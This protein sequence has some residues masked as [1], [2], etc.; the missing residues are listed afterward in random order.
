MDFNL[1]LYVYKLL[2]PKPNENV[3][4]MCAS[5]GNKTTH[6]AQLMNDTGRLIA[7]DKSKSRTLV[8]KENIQRFKFEC[9]EC[10]NFDATKAISGTSVNS[11]TPPFKEETFDKILLDA[12]CS[13][14]G[15]RPILKSMITKKSV[16]SFP[17]L[18]KRLLEVGMKLLKIDGILVYS[19]CSVL[20]VEN[21]LNVAWI[22][23][24]Y[25]NKIELIDATP[26]FGGHGFI[27]SGLSY[28]QCR[29]IQRF[30][31][32]FEKNSVQNHF[33]DSIGFF[34]CK[35]RKLSTIQL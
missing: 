20:E 8:L 24:K 35:F 3:L 17:K 30:G 6:L 2:D 11:W 21:E 12:P 1:L 29:K 26:F 7:L 10:Y 25:G 5:P 23:E 27:N 32:N 15:N 4:D 13:G 18:Q 9:V 14:L 16:V 31:P 22:L 19:T 33:I 34:I 28:E